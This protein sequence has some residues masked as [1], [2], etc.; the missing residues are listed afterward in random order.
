MTTATTHEFQAETKKLLDIVINSLYTE[1]D[2]F[3]RELISNA[4]DALEKFRHESLMHGEE[5]L[6]DGHMPLEITIDLDEK[7]KLLTITDTGIGMTKDELLANLGTIAH[8]GSNTFLTQLAEAA[9]KDVSLIGQFGVGFYSAFMA[10]ATVRV[11]SRSWD[12]SEGHE[13][14]SDGTGT[15]TVSECPGLHRGTKVIVELKEGCEDYAKKWK[16]ESIIKQY[17]AFVPFAI[18]LEGETVNTVQALWTRNRS[19]IKDE[20]YAEFYKFIANVSEEPM[21]RLHFSTDAPLAINALIFVPK[22]NLEIMGFGK[23]DPGVNLYCQRILIDQHSE[24]IL[25]EWLRFLKGVID[26]EDLP[27]NISRQALQD[28]ALVAKIRRVISKRFLKFLEEEAKKDETGYLEF[29]KTFGIYLKEGITSDFEYRTELGKLLRFETS[30]SADGTPV[31]LSDYLLRLQP[32]QQEIYYING[33]NRAAIESGPYIEMFRKKDVE[34]IYTIEPIDDFVL[35]YLGEFEGKKLVSAD[36][37]DLK[38]GGEDKPVEEKK[39]QAEPVLDD[40]VAADLVGWLKEKLKEQVAD[41]SISKRLVDSPAVIVNPDGFMTSSMERIMA[42]GRFEKGL[43]PEIGKKNL[44]I[45]PGNPLIR[46]L[47][48]LITEDEPFAVEIARQIYDNAMIQAGLLVDPLEMVARNYRIL[49][50]VV[51]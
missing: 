48:E 42:A 19:E 41:V 27:L 23:I 47:S 12:G 8:S 40:Q 51:G 20:E 50:R 21:Y 49:N 35:S 11:R 4:A 36:K 39:E 6:F 43:K 38:L 7:K 5:E 9:R 1:R 46:R 37:A 31:S 30:K 25:P 34:L 13:W 44:E 26:S 22:D 16:V 3:I 28:N 15:F 14:V 33:P 18:K 2:V 24:T 32:D 10:G 45:N 29:W 17:S